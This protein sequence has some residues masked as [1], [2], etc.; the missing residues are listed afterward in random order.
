MFILANLGFSACYKREK[1]YLV[2]FSDI[3]CFQID[4]LKKKILNANQNRNFSQVCRQVSYKIART[5]LTFCKQDSELHGLLKLKSV[6]SAAV[7]N[8]G[9]MPAWKIYMC[10]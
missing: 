9:I 5:E 7:D 1:I 10:E 8:Q 2:V 4:D 3:S 6:N